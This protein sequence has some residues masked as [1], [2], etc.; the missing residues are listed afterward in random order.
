M[1]TCELYKLVTLK[2][3]PLTYFHGRKIYPLE[4]LSGKIQRNARLSGREFTSSKCV[5]VAEMLS[6]GLNQ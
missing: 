1:H 3:M 6:Q 5:A 4:R 2:V